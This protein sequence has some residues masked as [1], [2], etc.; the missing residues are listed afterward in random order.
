MQNAATNRRHYSNNSFG[1]P[2]A[3]DA[4]RTVGTEKLTYFVFC[5]INPI[6]NR[7]P[8]KSSRDIGSVTNDAAKRGFRLKPSLHLFEEGTRNGCWRW[9]S[10]TRRALI[11]PAWGC[12]INSAIDLQEHDPD[13][14][15]ASLRRP[16]CQASHSFIIVMPR[17]LPKL[18]YDCHQSHEGGSSALWPIQRL[19]V[20][21]FNSPCIS[22]SSPAL[23]RH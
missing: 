2:A 14:L 18:F 7:F 9:I 8:S 12:A 13:R 19:V 20:V 1:A 23:F 16:V 11:A 6:L 22:W 10:K 5:T 3:L 15:P 21:N 4:G 17:S